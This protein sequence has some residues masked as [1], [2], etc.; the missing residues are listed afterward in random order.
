[1]T[2]DHAGDV[3]RVTG[4]NELDA[5]TATNF[6]QAVLEAM[7]D[8]IRHIEV[9]LSGTAFLDSCGLGTLMVLRKLVY[10]RDGSV[11]LLN[12]APAVQQMLQLTR[13]YR[14]LE[15]VHSEEI[16]ASPV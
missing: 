11:R 13:L 10:H 9:D 5:A 8:E 3:L 15:V 2:I 14:L 12:P 1:M 7:T 16:A 6:Q 4:V